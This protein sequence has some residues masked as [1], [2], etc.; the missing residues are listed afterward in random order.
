MRKTN[1][2]PNFLFF[3]TDQHRADWLGCY[4]HPVVKTPSIDSIAASGTR[5]DS[6]YVAS[7]VCMPNRASFMTGRYPS[8]HGLRSNGARLPLTATTFV[9][10]LA[11]AGYH[12]ASIGKSHLQPFTGLPPF[13]YGDHSDRLI[14]E[15][16]STDTGNYYQEEP[17]QYT[18]DGHYEFETPYYGF[19]HVEMVTLH[20]HKPSGHYGQWFRENVPNWKDLHDPANELPHN[21]SCPQAYRTPIP[22]EHYNTAWIAD[23]AI[24]YINN[25]S[26]DEPFFSFVSF[27]DPHHPFNPPGKYWDMYQP[28][29]FKVRL[30]YSAHQNPTPPMQ[31]LEANYQGAGE[32]MNMQTAIRIGDRELQEAMALTAGMVS[33]VDNHIGR[34]I[35]ALKESGQ[36]ENTVICFN[37]DHGDYLGDFNILLKGLLP[38]KSLN[39]VPFIWSDPADRTGKSTNTIASTVDIATTIMQRAGL[40]SYN[41]IQGKSF[42]P[43]I[44]NGDKHRDETMIEFNDG[45]AKFGFER[46]ARVRSLITQDWRISMYRDQDW[47]E[48]YDLNNDPDETNNLWNDTRFMEIRFK[49]TERLAHHLMHQMDESPLPDRLA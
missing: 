29:Q 48:L 11:A 38:M 44:R 31:W 33:C 47:G 23:R 24:E 37:A 32:Q 8:V 20:G 30:P 3:M 42:L 19:Q 43:T 7:P 10:V 17:E 9:D 26:E 14:K 40:N 16:W 18:S 36:Y 2:R 22:D 39:R 21:Y 49:L 28:E 25:A 45:G 5:F 46:P 12:T 35:E 15:A 34:V 1:K 13:R 41:G 4:G 27:P 6:F